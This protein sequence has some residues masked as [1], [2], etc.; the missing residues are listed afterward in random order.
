MTLPKMRF[1]LDGSPINRSGRDGRQP[2]FVAWL[3]S[4]AGWVWS[5]YS[6]LD[7]YSNI[8]KDMVFMHGLVLGPLNFIF[9]G[10][11]AIFP[12]FF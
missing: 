2:S 4:V 6:E 10:L 5:V 1:M 11:H 8:R 12:A 9:A 3:L 7:R